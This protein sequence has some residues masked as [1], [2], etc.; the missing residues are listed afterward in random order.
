MDAKETARRALMVATVCVLLS[1]LFCVIEFA[2]VELW[3]RVASG[4]AWW[5]RLA[6]LRAGRL[7]MALW[8]ALGSAVFLGA[9]GATWYLLAAAADEDELYWW[10]LQGEARARA[11]LQGVRPDPLGVARMALEIEGEGTGQRP[12]TIR[13]W[14]D[15]MTHTPSADEVA[16]LRAL[17]D[18]ARTSQMVADRVVRQASRPDLALVNFAGREYTALELTGQLARIRSTIGALLGAPEDIVDKTTA[19]PAPGRRR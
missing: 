12:E 19:T 2:D 3:R 8:F 13:R 11:V 17:F 14:L 9:S 18:Y 10:R 15:A 7:G 1:A 6:E 4:E 16:V 5:E